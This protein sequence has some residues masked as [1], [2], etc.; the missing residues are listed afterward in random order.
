MGTP[1]AP[2]RPFVDGTAKSSEEIREE[3]TTEVEALGDERRQHLE[4]LRGEVAT[5]VEEL[6]GRVDVA[7]RVHAGKDEV[8]A[9]ARWRMERTRTM[10]GG[11][12][13]TA[14]RAARARPGAL[15]AALGVLLLAVIGCRRYVARR[16]C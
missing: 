6:V 13:S 2:D 14:L 4:E 16:A 15:A 12:A 5:T 9:A 1:P 7:S 11:T 10:A 8:L 3:V